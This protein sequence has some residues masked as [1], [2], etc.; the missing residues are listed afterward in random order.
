M[1]NL[2]KDQLFTASLFTALKIFSNS[3]VQELEMVMVNSFFFPDEACLGFFP[4]KAERCTLDLVL[5]L[6][7]N[8]AVPLKGNEGLV[9]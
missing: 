4:N 7:C 2:D 5:K 9:K 1:F 8:V 6:T 3:T